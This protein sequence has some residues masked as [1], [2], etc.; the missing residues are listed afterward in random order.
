MIG[1]SKLY[2]GAVE[3][4]DLLRYRRLSSEL[5]SHL[6][7]FSEDKK[8]VI[9]WNVTRA[10]NLS[11]VHCYASATPGPAEG[12][13]SRE[14][15]LALARNLADFGAP[16]ILFSGGEPLFHP[17]I[18]ELVELTVKSGARAVLSTNGLL[19]TRDW[20][21]KL[22][23]IGLS[24]VGVSLDGLA[25][26]HDR[27]RGLA[28][29]FDLAL[30]A[31]DTAK[32]ANLKVGLRLTITKSNLGD[33]GQIFDLLEEEGVPRICF[34]HLVDNG[35]RPELA[36]ESLSHQETRAAV[37]LIAK[38]TWLLRQK[39]FNPEVL[40]VDNPADGPYLYLKMREEGRL[41]EA[42]NALELLRLNGGASSGHGVGAISWDGL[43]YPDQFWRTRV[44]GSIRERPFAEIWRDPGNELLMKLKDK[45]SHVTGRCRV[46]GFLE[47]CGGGL[48]ARADFATGDPW[49]PD[50]ACYLTDEEISIDLNGASAVAAEM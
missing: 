37:D 39:G 8:P 50:P 48:R 45:K 1:V 12:E 33:I 41:H 30:Q 42:G 22:R 24:Y 35:R 17:H 15:A 21:L 38:R 9:A 5:P 44:L 4:S 40:T 43:V 6:L 19:L 28:G 13:L 34:Y 31:I 26:A 32:K 14:E 18:F 46:C 27:M 29:A 23:D 11:C 10:C 47:I 16:V 3:P 49:A 20:A 2:C 7:Q 36:A 25:E